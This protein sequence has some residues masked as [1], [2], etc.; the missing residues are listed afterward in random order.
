[1]GKTCGNGPLRRRTSRRAA[2]ARFA[3][4]PSYV[5][6]VKARLRRTGEATPGPPRNHVP[7]RLTPL[8]DALRARVA[9]GSGA[10]LA[11]LRA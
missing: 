10:T 8:A 1:M 4:S 9:S 2:A 3:V 5:S 6:K 11:E 7:L